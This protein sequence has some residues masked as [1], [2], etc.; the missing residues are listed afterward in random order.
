MSVSRLPSAIQKQTLES[1]PNV[2]SQNIVCEFT[3]LFAFT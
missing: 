2:D 1:P 3:L